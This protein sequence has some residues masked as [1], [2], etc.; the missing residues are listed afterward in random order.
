M[1]LRLDFS[2][3]QELGRSCARELGGVRSYRIDCIYL[4]HRTPDHDCNALK[5]DSETGIC[6][7]S[8]S[9]GIGNL[10][11]LIVEF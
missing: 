3:Y 5:H 2:V 4:W 9:Q 1:L 6:Y 8:G 11:V 10:E 7:N